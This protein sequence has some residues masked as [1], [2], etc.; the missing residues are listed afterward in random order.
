[1]V[2]SKVMYD[3]IIFGNDTKD[4]I[5]SSTGTRFVDGGG[6]NYGAH[7]AVALGL[8]VAAV[9][10]LAREDFH[11][12]RALERLGI[13]VFPRTT[14]T[15][16]HMQLEYPG[17]NVDERILTCTK[18]AGAYG[19]DQFEGLQAR[20]ILIN[21][22]IREEV[23]PEV[24]EGLRERESLLVADAQGFL[25]IIAPDH[26]LVYGT[27]PEKER[28]LSQLDVL[29]ADAVEAEFLTGES[30][31]HK[32]AR[33]LAELGPREIVLTHRDGILVYAEERYHEATFHPEKLVGRSGRGDTCIASY[34]AK[35]LTEAP[36]EAILWSAA[37]TS[38]KM[39]AEGPFRGNKTDVQ[40]LVDRK[41]RS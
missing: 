15:S 25:R 12:V 31:I 34:M 27:W 4:T 39:E 9:T 3:V 8:N 32:A 5:V 13:D 30:D 41:Y 24:V 1:M 16:T 29:K 10:R 21:A 33:I 2:E 36:E 28:V 26:R 14:D 19:L 23:T 38:L 18:S 20:A 37:L 11:V 7:A 22:S 6:F 40:E 35:R 17:S